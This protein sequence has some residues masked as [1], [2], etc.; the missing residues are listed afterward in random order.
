MHTSL[1]LT[2][3]WGSMFRYFSGITCPSS[4][5]TTRTQFSWIVRSCRCGLVS[6]CGN[7]CSLLTSWDQPTSTTAHNSHENCVSD[8]A[9]W[10]W[11]S[12]ARKMSR[13]W[14]S[15][16]RKWKWS[17]HQ[18]GWVYYVIT[19]LWCTVNRT[20]NASVCPQLQVTFGLTNKWFGFSLQLTITEKLTARPRQSRSFNLLS[21]A[22]SLRATRFNIQKFYTVLAL[23]WVF[24][25]DLR[26][27]SDFSCIQH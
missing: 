25:T 13:H 17:V 21:L 2:L 6:G 15:I 19:S 7:I 11:A 16:K 27:D 9:S 4:G 26:T 22:V 18:V 23:R 3:Y 12:N 24:C 5:G 8:S 10:R 1:A 20:L 14:N